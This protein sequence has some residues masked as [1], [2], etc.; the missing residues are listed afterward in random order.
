VKANF[1]TEGPAGKTEPS[2]MDTAH[3]IA[4]DRTGPGGIMQKTND[5]DAN[6]YW[7]IDNYEALTGLA[8]YRWLAR[9]VGDTREERWAAA[10]YASLLTAVNKTLNATISASHLN[11]LPCSM[12]GPNT[13]NRCAN[14]EDANWAA[15][16]L[17][18][19]WAWDG[20]LFGAPR[21]GPGISLI[22][23]TYDYGFGRLAGHLPPN[24]FGGYPTQ[25]SSTAYNAGY[26]EWGLASAKHRN[27]GILSYQFMI[28]NGQSGPYSW[29]ESQQFPNPG[30]PWTGTHPEAGNGSSP[31][32]W[33][34]ANTNL[35]LLDSLVA[36]RAD[37]SLIVGRGV[38]SAWLGSSQPIS[39]AKVP[40]TRRSPPRAEHP[41]Q[42]HLSHLDPVRAG[43]RRASTVPAACVCGQHRQRQ[44]GLSQRGNR[45]GHPAP[46]RADGDG[47]AEARRGLTR[48]HAGRDR[49]PSSPAGRDLGQ[50]RQVPVRSDQVGQA[51]PGTPGSQVRTDLR[52]AANK[53]GRHLPH[54]LGVDP[55]PAALS[56]QLFGAGPPLAGDAERGER[57]ELQL[58]E[59][60]AGG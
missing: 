35:V 57:T 54:G 27:Q 10:Q 20:Y 52:H 58:A 47:A 36:E 55:A 11:Y 2:I 16:F 5:I 51:E 41:C 25:Y 7:T 49:G 19:R 50:Y 6:G 40:T 46:E 48:G 60:V 12:T 22:D 15:P 13:A 28:T 24:T 37:G 17:F 33:G 44:R 32:A 30:A 26:G 9:Q 23:A 31:H 39:L 38:P 59:P 56:D 53:D 14:A 1:A 34:M 8:T 42:R 21:S 3:L 43:T 18:G 29:W 45:N 4:T